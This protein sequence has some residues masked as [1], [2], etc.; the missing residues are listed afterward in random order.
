MPSPLDYPDISILV[1]VVHTHMVAGFLGGFL[2]G[3]FATI[4]GCAAFGLKNPGGAIEGNGKQ[5]WLQIVG[6]LFIIGLNLF[7]TSIICV[8]IKYVLRIPLR[9][10]EQ[11][12]LVGDDAV[13]GEEAY[14]LFFEGERSHISLHTTGFE[15]GHIIDTNLG[16]KEGSGHESPARPSAAK[17]AVE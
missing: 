7:M 16:S 10:N 6:A 1:G 17:M 9:L 14:A 15:S 11:Q 5:V 13:H 3:I 12:L 4:D 8:F 2:T